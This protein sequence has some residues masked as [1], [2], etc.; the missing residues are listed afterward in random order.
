MQPNTA[1]TSPQESP[2]SDDRIQDFFSRHGGP[3][4]SPTREGVEPGDRG[5]SEVYAGDGHILRCEWRRSGTRKEFT[6]TEIPPRSPPDSDQT[7]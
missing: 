7:E 4:R 5:W 3:G 6:Y 2:D 1:D